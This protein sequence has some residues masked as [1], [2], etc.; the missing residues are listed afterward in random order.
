MPTLIGGL[1][2]AAVLVEAAWVGSVNGAVLLAALAAGGV[3]AVVARR[4]RR[5][6]RRADR[7]VAAALHPNR[8]RD[9]DD[10][11]VRAAKYGRVKP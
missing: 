3:T 2:A 5:E 10:R 9:R 4:L 11:L 6:M 7:L 1:A 8:Q